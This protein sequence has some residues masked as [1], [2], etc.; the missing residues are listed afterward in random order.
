[1][2]VKLG[3]LD[4]GRRT[5]TLSSMGKVLDVIDYAEKADEMG[6]SRYW[7]SEHHNYSNMDAWS[8]PLMMV[9]ILLQST[10]KIK[11]GVGGVLLNYYSPYEIALHFKLM[12]NLFPGRLDLGIANGTPPVQV[13]KF[14]LHR[15][16][17]KIPDMMAE[18][19][20]SLHQFFN[21]EEQMVEKYQVVIPPYKGQVPDTFMLG[22]SFRHTATAIEYR[23]NYARSMFHSTKPV[24]YE[25]DTI[26]RYKEDYYNVHGR[27]PQVIVA[28]SG[29]CRKTEEEAKHLAET[30]STGNFV[31]SFIGSL[32]QFEDRINQY[33][34]A[35]G[36]DEF[37]FFDL[38][39]DNT[40]R[41]ESL[42]YLQSI[43]K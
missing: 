14:M 6:F 22:S 25:R 23:M 30:A 13:G 8:S 33:R 11:I 9:P 1:M 17:N 27:L 43:I 36:V 20:K 40:A 29:V 37:M 10:S 21:H 24:E 7:I 42:Y 39:L 18:K 35:F 5:T 41:L 38:L 32:P 31:N 3:L 12:E 4:F 34:E 16:R 15:K 2:A 19:M 28:F 26:A